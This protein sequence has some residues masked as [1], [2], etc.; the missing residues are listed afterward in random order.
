MSL[1]Q[2]SPSPS[3]D[4]E[5]LEDVELIQAAANGQRRALAALYDRHAP[6]MLAL[7]LRVLAQRQ[8]AEDLVHDVFLEAWKRAADYDSARGSVRAWL[9]LRTRSRALDRKKSVRVKRSVSLETESLPE[10]G[11]AQADAAPDQRLLL[12]VLGELPAEQREV[13][14]L[15]YFE[16]LSSSEISAHIGIPIGTVKSR[17]AAALSKLRG[18]LREGES[19]VHPIRRP[20]GQP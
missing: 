5:T 7:A 11:Q 19:A 8:E 3:A 9:L 2:S 12:Q 6:T 4:L 16:G 18:V 13:L 10:V 14:L 20:G 1:V 15:G 17:V